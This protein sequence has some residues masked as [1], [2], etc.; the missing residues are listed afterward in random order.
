MMDFK[1]DQEKCIQCMICASDCP[2]LI[3]NGKS[4]YPEIKEDKEGLCIKCQHCL[5]VCPSGAI[6]IWG[7]KPE[8]SIP[9]NGNILQAQE[10]E[11]LI[12]TRRSIRKFKNEEL[13]KALIHS[14]LTT[15]AYAPTSQNDNAVLFTVVDDK[16]NLSKLRSLTYEHIKKA[17]DEN[18]LP[19]KLSFMNKF[20][21]L[22]YTKQ[23]DILFRNA[24]HLLI[25]SAPKHTTNPETDSIIALSYFELLANSNGIGTLWNGYARWV[26]KDVAP[27]IRTKIGIPNNHIINAVLLFGKAD[28]RYARSIQSNGLNLNKVSL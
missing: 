25:A 15:S 10:M 13:D 11:K 28:V 8:D 9:V 12:K 23:I 22:W 20:Q 16:I 17:H 6:S 19:E 4:E 7:K 1:V 21:D 3:I 18:R 5:A 26:L 14:M 27:E 24:P 2:V